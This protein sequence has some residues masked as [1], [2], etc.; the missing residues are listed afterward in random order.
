MGGVQR[1]RSLAA[2]VTGGLLVLASCGGSDDEPSGSAD[3]STATSAGAQTTAGGSSATTGGGGATTAPAEDIDDSKELRIGANIAAQAGPF[4]DPA[5]YN[6]NPNAQTYVN[7]M[8]DSLIHETAEGHEPGLALEWM[9]PDAS[10]VEI[11]LRP[12]VTFS[13]GTPFDAEAVKAAWERM[14]AGGNTTIPGYIRSIETIEVLDDLKLRVSFSANSAGQ[15]INNGMTY[16]HYGLGIPSPADTAP[17]GE[18][19]IG[20]GPYLFESST[21]E[22]ITL[23]R[24]EDYWDRDNYHFAKI[25]F[26]QVASGAP[27]VTALASDTVDIAHIGPTLVDGATQQN[28]QIISEP[29][30]ANN[31]FVFCR[32]RPPFDNLE[33]RRAVVSSLD[34]DAIN[35]GAYSGLADPNPLILATSHP[36]YDEA[37]AGTVQDSVS[38]PAGVIKAAGLEGA[39][40]LVLHPTARGEDPLVAQIVQAELQDLGLEVEL[41]AGADTIADIERLSPDMAASATPVASVALML[42]TEGILNPCADEVA[43]PVLD[44]LK[45]AQDPSLD[46]AASKEAWEEYQRLGWEV[47]PL[48]PMVTV[49]NIFAATTALKGVE[50]NG[51]TNISSPLGGLHLEGVYLADD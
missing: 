20:A 9:A 17:V 37:L 3:G 27:V 38:D 34:R 2:V 29:S 19:R 51:V 5:A 32:T 46:A 25:T 35:E 45:A 14:L 30:G 26:R 15:F 31:G 11:T 21:N 50:E 28:L 13:D 8:Y 16:S 24:N 23:V 44:A 22:S 41:V 6:G 39:K 33:V 48:M 18:A 43:L 49:P 40:V 47:A 7:L 1:R 42:E 4:F 10:T 12:D 36:H